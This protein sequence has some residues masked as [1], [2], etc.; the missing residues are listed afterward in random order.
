MLVNEIVLIIFAQL[1]A[2]SSIAAG[3]DAPR[4]GGAGEEDPFLSVFFVLALSC[5]GG[6]A[7]CMVAY[8]RVVNKRF[9]DDGKVSSRPTSPPPPSPLPAHSCP[10]LPP[11]DRLFRSTV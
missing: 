7:S 6:I 2:L 9:K 4:I 10:F 8:Q 1:A 5:V 11:F 3:P